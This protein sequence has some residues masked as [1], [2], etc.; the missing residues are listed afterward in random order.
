MVHLLA[1]TSRKASRFVYYNTALFAL[2]NKVLTSN[3]LLCQRSGN[4]RFIQSTWSQN[5]Q[6]A[7]CKKRWLSTY[8]PPAGSFATSPTTCHEHQTSQYISPV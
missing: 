5:S 2:L 7:L 4:Q 1:W 8:L 3:H 6:P